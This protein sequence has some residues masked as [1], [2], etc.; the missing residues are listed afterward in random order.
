MTCLFHRCII[1]LAKAIGSFSSN[2]IW[3]I[4]NN[5]TLK[6]SNVEYLIKFSKFFDVT[7]DYLVGLSDEK[8]SIPIQKKLSDYSTD[9]L[10]KEIHKR[11]EGF[12]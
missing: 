6:G 5:K 10:L 11:M 1:E 3:K 2:V 4:E 7:T 8:E 12:K 9:E